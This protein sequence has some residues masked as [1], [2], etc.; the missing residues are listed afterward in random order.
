MPLPI[1]KRR[2]QWNPSGF[3][4]PSLIAH[5]VYSEIPPKVEYELSEI[6]HKLQ[7]VLAALE[8]WGNEHIGYLKKRNGTSTCSR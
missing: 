4:K 5:N 3:R 7:S 1:R 6:G 8:V 2:W